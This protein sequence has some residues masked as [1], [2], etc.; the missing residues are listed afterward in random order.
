ML[1]PSCSLVVVILGAVC[2]M[3]E[4]AENAATRRRVE[5]Y[6]RDVMGASLLRGSSAGGTDHRLVWSVKWRF[7]GESRQTTKSDRLSHR[8]LWYAFLSHERIPGQRLRGG[9]AR[10][11]AVR[12]RYGGDCRRH[13][14]SEGAIL[15]DAGGAG[16]DG[17]GR[18]FRH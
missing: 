3:K 2:A 10:R 4:I 9:C 8:Y 11:T 18:A 16:A 12:I 5:G 14:G 17:F 7:F 6:R 13:R 1:K 15:A